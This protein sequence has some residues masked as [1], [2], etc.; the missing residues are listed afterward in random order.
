MH[1]I[2]LTVFVLTFCLSQTAMAAVMN[3]SGNYQEYVSSGGNNAISF[4]ISSLY[5]MNVSS[6]KVKIKISDDSDN[7]KR[8][9][10]RYVESTSVEYTG[11]TLLN[12]KKT[13]TVTKASYF[14]NS[15]ELESAALIVNGVEIDKKSTFESGFLFEQT[16]RKVNGAH[17]SIYEFPRWVEHYI[18]TVHLE[19]DTYL[20]QNEFFYL[21]CSVPEESLDNLGLLN[22]SVASLSGDFNIDEAVLTVDATA[23]P[24]PGAAWLLGSGLV[25]LMGIRRKMK[26]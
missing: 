18:K 14:N 16:S 1:R 4:D 17:E 9:L 2:I 26:A 15:L 11:V 6:A 23:T 8:S 13:T 10:N 7:S 21:Y 20:L 12:A 22:F 19:F 24:I 3:F 25:G 5:G